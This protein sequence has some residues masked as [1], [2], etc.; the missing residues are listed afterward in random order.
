MI[1]PVQSRQVSISTHLHSSQKIP[2]LVATRI[3][4]G[5]KNNWI[6]HRSHF[7]RRRNRK[8]IKAMEEEED[9]SRAHTPR[10]LSP[11]LGLGRVG[12][13]GQG[14]SRIEAEAPESPRCL[15]LRAVYGLQEAALVNYK[16]K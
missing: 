10:V 2:W 9:Q 5:E 11:R 7:P 8:L 1:Q 16:I 14:A 13:G 4:M 3:G 6:R 15:Y 12:G